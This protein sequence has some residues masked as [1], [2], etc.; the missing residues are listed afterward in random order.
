MGAPRRLTKDV[1]VGATPTAD[2][3][4][5]LAL[6]GVKSVINNQYDEEEIRVLNSADSEKTAHRFGMEYAHSKVADRFNV[7]EEEVQR[8]IAAYERLPKPVFVYCRAGFRA[9]LVWGMSQIGKMDID[10]IIEVIFEAGYDLTMIGK[11]Q[12]KK[13]LERLQQS[14][15]A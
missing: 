12:M 14:E 5:Q 2:M 9:S 1:W 4:S 10:D 13:R 7:T 15:Q 8:F 11:P 3:L 6:W